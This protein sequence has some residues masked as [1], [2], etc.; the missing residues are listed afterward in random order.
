LQNQETQSVLSD[1]SNNNLC[2]EV[3]TSHYFKRDPV[4]SPAKQS[5]PEVVLLDDELLS[6]PKKEIKIFD[7]NC[8]LIT[9]TPKQ[10][11]SMKR[12]LCSEEEIPDVIPAT[13]TIKT[14]KINLSC[15]HMKRSKVGTVKLEKHFSDKG[16]KKGFLLFDSLDDAYSCNAVRDKVLSVN[17]PEF[18]IQHIPPCKGLKLNGNESTC[19]QE[20]IK[21]YDSEDCIDLKYTSNCTK[22]GN[23]S[24]K[25]KSHQL[26]NQDLNV[27]SIKQYVNDTASVGCGVESNS[28][29]QQIDTKDNISLSSKFNGLPENT[30]SC[31]P[32]SETVLLSDIANK[33]TVF[34]EK[35]SLNNPVVSKN[36]VSD[37]NIS[38]A[39]VKQYV[40]LNNDR[41]CSSSLQ[42]INKSE[43]RQSTD[44]T[45]STVR[46]KETVFSGT[47]RYKCNNNY[48]STDANNKAFGC[49]VVSTEDETKGSAIVSKYT[50]S[51]KENDLQEFSS[52]YDSVNMETSDGSCPKSEEDGD[53]MCSRV[54]APAAVSAFLQVKTESGA[55][56][57]NYITQEDHQAWP[58]LEDWDFSLI[59]EKNTK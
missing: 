14:R 12:K 51:S 32:E 53:V 19:A 17:K 27:P 44:V 45:D 48:G 26:N 56:S 4:K 21:N 59:D 23:V 43:S 40:D 13:P 49:D 50:V 18:Q 20:N 41:I 5:S 42:E 22:Y 54:Q 9:I 15:K 52:K 24:E 3:Q 35:S 47:L 1:K 8:D 29:D 25:V 55:L 10:T 57:S 11:S 46:F 37:C 6:S 58:S 7:E 28:S 16:S 33:H 38:K 36:K 34:L 39:A 30:V 2:A 31:V